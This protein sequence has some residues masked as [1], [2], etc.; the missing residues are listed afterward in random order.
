MIDVSEQDYGYERLAILHAS[1]CGTQV[2]VLGL[3]DNGLQVTV[4]LPEDIVRGA[5]T[6]VFR[7]PSR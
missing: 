4:E 3:T 1:A 6:V 2:R 5:P 7:E